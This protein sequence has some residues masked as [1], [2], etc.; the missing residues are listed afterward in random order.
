MRCVWLKAYERSDRLPLW[1]GHIDN[2]RPPVDNQL[3]DTSSW[4][5]LFTGRDRQVPAGWAELDERA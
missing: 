1:R 4:V 5:N 2:V 3:K